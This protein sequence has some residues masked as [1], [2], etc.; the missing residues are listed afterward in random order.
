MNSVEILHDFS[1]HWKHEYNSFF[2]LAYDFNNERIVC[3]ISWKRNWIMWITE[4][5]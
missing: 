2:S 3:W 4:T 5:R 1:L